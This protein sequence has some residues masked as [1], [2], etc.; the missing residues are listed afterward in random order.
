M[1]LF[2]C[3][4]ILLLLLVLIMFYTIFFICCHHVDPNGILYQ[5]HTLL[6]VNYFLGVGKWVV[7]YKKGC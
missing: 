4:F 5:L 3:H 7:F 1:N 6:W 2:V